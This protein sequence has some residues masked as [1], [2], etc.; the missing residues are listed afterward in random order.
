MSGNAHSDAAAVLLLGICLILCA[1]W[2]YGASPAPWAI[3]SWAC[4]AAVAI[5]YLA[6]ALG[7][8]RFSPRAASL[9]V[10]MLGGHVLY[11]ALMSLAVQALRPGP[12]DINLALDFAL[13]NAPACLLQIAFV[14]PAAAGL[15]WPALARRRPGTQPQSEIVAGVTDSRQF[16][17]SVLM[18][19]STRGVEAHLALRDLA[20]KARELLAED[21]QAPGDRIPESPGEP[22]EAIVVAEGLNDGKSA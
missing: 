6:V 21:G 7:L 8:E 2:L 12:A 1:A 16:L 14:V 9:W 22:V 15:I 11:A 18:L 3:P 10:L 13:R 5:I 20:A 19:D 4:P 17:T